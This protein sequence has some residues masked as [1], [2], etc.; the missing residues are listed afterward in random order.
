MPTTTT[1]NPKAASSADPSLTALM[2]VL[3]LSNV[4]F[5]SQALTYWQ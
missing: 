1:S 5:V 2:V 4:W 3:G